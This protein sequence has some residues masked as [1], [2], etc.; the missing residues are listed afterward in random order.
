MLNLKKST[1]IIL[2]SSL[3]PLAASQAEIIHAENVTISPPTGEAMLTFKPTTTEWDIDTFGDDFNFYDGFF[4]FYIGNGGFADMALTNGLEITN[5]VSSNAVQEM[6]VLGSNVPPQQVY[7]NNTTGS[8]W[9][10]AMTTD[11]EFKVSFDGTGKVEA[12]FFK[13]GNLTIA[14]TLTQSSDRN[15][16]QDIVAVDNKKVLDAV[17]AMPISTWEYKADDGVVH[18]GPMAQDFHAAFGLG[19]TPKGISTI[20]T[21]GVALAAIKGLNEIVQLKDSEIAV[22]KQEKD[23]EVAELKAELT[24]LRELVHALATKDQV[25]MVQ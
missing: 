11:D 19:S 13:N 15:S 23:R 25:S 14:G 6:L 7:T 21:A 5:F 16:K 20:D 9:F 2:I 4:R 10:L 1:L 3:V 8:T 24:E 17:A 22:L 12:K 18:M